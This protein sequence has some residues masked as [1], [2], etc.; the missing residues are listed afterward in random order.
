MQHVLTCVKGVFIQ[1]YI[2][3]YSC[4]ILIFFSS[5][6]C[7]IC[8]QA[9]DEEEEDQPLSL[10]WP[11][12]NRKRFTYLFIMPIVLPL[13]LTL[14]DVRK[15]V[16]FRNFF[17]ERLLSSRQ[18]LFTFS[19]SFSFSVVKKVLPCYI[20]GGHLLDCRILL[21]NGVVGSPGIRSTSSFDLKVSV[22]R[23]KKCLSVSIIPI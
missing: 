17:Q 20:P 11:E 18:D 15:T 9:E 12:S 7:D 10:S 2:Y 23:H 14:P 1:V 3:D 4:F 22:Q 13:W 5:S 16:T 21:S 6:S 19:F 8:C